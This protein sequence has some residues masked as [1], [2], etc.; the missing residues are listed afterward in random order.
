MQTKEVFLQKYFG[1]SEFRNGQA[2][3]V[4]QLL[5]G[6]SVIAVM[7][8][9]AGKSLCYQ[10]PA[11]VMEGL[12]L[13]VS[14]L[15]SLMKDQVRSLKERGIEAAY[16]SSGMSKQEYGAAVYAARNNKCK[17][18]YVSPERLQNEQFKAFVSELKRIVSSGVSV[19]QTVFRQS[20]RTAFSG[21]VYSNGN[22]G[23]KT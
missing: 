22:A 17:L 4:E 19:Y 12:T 9:G 16:L 20:A 13:V 21:S 5:A 18:L 10:L 15:I 14:P 11:L 8:T 3:L 23:C 6:G 2:E 7:P 1:Y